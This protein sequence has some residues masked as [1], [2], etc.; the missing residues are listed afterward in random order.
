MTFVCQ[1]NEAPGE[2]VNAGAGGGV[3]SCQGKS[4]CTCLL[5]LESCR[6]GA[7]LTMVGKKGKGRD[8]I[9]GRVW[10]HGRRERRV[11]CVG[12]WRERLRSE[13]TGR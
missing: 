1:C 3:V 13:G 5:F 9:E 10:R 12:G 7:V 8:G 4:K 11:G 6:R 2:C